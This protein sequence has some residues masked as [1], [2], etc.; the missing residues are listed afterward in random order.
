MSKL[1]K[2]LARKRQHE[3]ISQKRAIARE[4]KRRLKE[5]TYNAI[6]TIIKDDSQA[7]KDSAIIDN[8]FKKSSFGI[9]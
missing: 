2:S 3:L 6:K 4:G 7:H 5:N 9:L 8:V 1:S